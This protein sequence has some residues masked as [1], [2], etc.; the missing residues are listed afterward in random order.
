MRICTRQDQRFIHI[1]PWWT[2][3]LRN[4]VWHIVRDPHTFT[5]RV[6]GWEIRN[7]ILRPSRL[8][9]YKTVGS[10]TLV[11]SRQQ[12]GDARRHRAVFRASGF[13][14]GRKGQGHRGNCFWTTA[15]VLCM[16][17]RPGSP[18]WMRMLT[19]GVILFRLLS[20][21]AA[22]LTWEPRMQAEL[23]PVQINI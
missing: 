13:V 6:E 7:S 10:I 21:R 20:K 18:F 2:P 15:T 1:V 23:S 14:P 19:G 3:S 4:S 12:K 16:R 17:R 22:G 9:S 8:H 5:E 11:C